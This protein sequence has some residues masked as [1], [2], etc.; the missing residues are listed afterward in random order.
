[1]IFVLGFLAKAGH[2]KSTVADHF[3][4]NRGAERMS[5]ADPL[6]RIAMTT[7]GFTSEQLWGTQE[8]KERPDPRHG[9]SGRSF[10]QKLGTDGMRSELGVDV[11]CR[12]LVKR[13]QWRFGGSA[14]HRFSGEASRDHFV[15]VDDVRFPD[16]A[17]YLNRL[18]L[19]SSE[20]LLN[21]YRHTMRGA[22]IKIVCTDAPA[23]EGA[24]SEH[25]SESS[26]DR[27]PDTEL[28]ATV[29]GSRALGV[30]HMIRGVEDA[31]RGVGLEGYCNLSRDES[32]LE[33][34]NWTRGGFIY[35]KVKAGEVIHGY[36]A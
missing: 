21:G 8:E 27:V 5:L 17:W 3:V 30:D 16:E 26:I 35:H 11:F 9:H 33:D 18:H 22:V 32:R 24:L 19:R 14:E 31:I 34:V 1:M 7:M 13:A 28:T 20:F 25:S 15:V 2:G 23:P 29:V 36:Q 10:C 6:K 12:S 4:R